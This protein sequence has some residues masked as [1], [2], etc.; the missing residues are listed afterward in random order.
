[1]YFVCSWC[2]ALVFGLE[3]EIDLLKLV[4][5]LAK[6][7]FCFIIT[8]DFI[9]TSQYHNTEL[10]SFEVPAPS[11]VP[12][13]NEYGELRVADT[14]SSSA[15]CEC[16]CCVVVGCLLFVYNVFDCFM[17]RCL[18]FRCFVAFKCWWLYD[19]VVCFCSIKKILKFFYLL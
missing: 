8:F 17:F 1:M 6:N 10:Q 7:W 12:V 2:L 9:A 15:G 4:Q 13:S 19:L 11:N 14:A 3:D 5:V 16:C 18:L